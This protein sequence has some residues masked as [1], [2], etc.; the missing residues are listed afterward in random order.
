[1]G[2]LADIN[3]GT[4]ESLST[5]FRAAGPFASELSSATVAGGATAP[6]PGSRARGA[7]ARESHAAE[8]EGGAIAQAARHITA[9]R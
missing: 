7:S 5:Y 2:W 3:G 8:P 6:E 9:A 4:Q 1:M